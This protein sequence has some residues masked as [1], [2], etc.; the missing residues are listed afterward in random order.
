MPAPIVTVNRG[1]DAGGNNYY[2]MGNPFEQ[3]DFF[4]RPKLSAAKGPVP[5]LAGTRSVE[6]RPGLNEQSLQRIEGQL[7]FHVPVDPKPAAFEAG[8]AGKEKTVHGSAVSLR[9]VKGDTVQL[10]F[11]G[12][13]E[14]ML[15]VRAFGADGKP[16]AMESWQVLPERRDVDD[17]FVVTFKGLPAKVEVMVAA[18][19]IERFFPFSLA[20]GATPG[21]PA[22]AEQ[23]YTGEPR[24]RA[25][26]AAPAIAAAPKAEP[27]VEPKAEPKA[28]P[29]PE[30]KPK[31]V[32]AAPAMPKETA[33]PAAKPR[34]APAPT[35][36]PSRPL[37]QADSGCVY[38]PVMTNEGIARCR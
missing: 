7:N 23:G 2:D 29:I 17:D 27:K 25:D 9:S 1:L 21:P 4:R 6:M 14:N 36:A 33:K 22:S 34:P 13:S 16:L 10:H 35:A 31:P 30:P 18:R 12:A 32:I 11:R 28:E 24:A 38:K 8:E 3:K 15:Q 37:G 19:I 20:R 5:H 26:Q